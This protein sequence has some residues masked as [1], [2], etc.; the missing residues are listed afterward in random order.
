VGTLVR[1]SHLLD[2]LSD[3]I[4]PILIKETRQ[5]LKSR[6]FIVTFLLML[7]A[8]W[9]ISVFG[10]LTAG[11][12][13]EYGSAGRGL[14]MAYFVVLA[15]A[16]FIVVP[17]TAYRGLLAERDHTTLELL[18]IT[19]LSPRQL[20]WGKLW[21]AM[22]QV[23]I[24]YSAI[25]PFIAFTSMLQGFD[26]MLVSFALVMSG[27][28]SLCLTM[29]TLMLAA[30]PQGKNLQGLM[31]L[32]IAVGMFA[33]FGFI[34]STI[35][36]LLMETIP[37]DE[38]EFWVG[39]GAFVIAAVSF[40]FLFTQVATA[41]LTFESDNRSTGIR[42]ACT[43]QF[44]L[45]WLTLALVQYLIVGS[46]SFADS[47]IALLAMWPVL[48]TAVS[49]FFAVTEPDYVSRR[50][51]RNVP[52]RWYTRLLI[53]PLLPG[54]HRGFVYLMLHLLA[55]PSILVLLFPGLFS[56]S[57]WA[58]WWIVTMELYIVAYLG[59]GA[60]FG[61][62]L[63]RV[64]AEIRPMHVRVIIFLLFALG[65]IV[66]YLPLL[67]N[68]LDYLWPYRLVRVTNPFIILN[69]TSV[70]YGGTSGDVAIHELV[71]LW[72][73]AALGLLL[74]VRPMVAG[75]LEILRQPVS[76]AI[77][78]ESTSPKPDERLAEQPA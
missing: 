65:Q 10:T 26:I 21:S 36:I 47:E 33:I 73:A 45:Y 54:G 37:F 13:L 16:I 40:F 42:V 39:V 78:S 15:L 12:S 34:M 41:H 22:A 53:S 3:W 9:L 43:A 69:E 4:N 17:Y 67:F 68:D 50:I 57:H 27:L 2:E 72:I 46:S 5:A 1:A 20:V 59:L 62:A 51:R 70:G 14:F 44:A 19:S 28:V 76:P 52:R 6:Q 31:T 71:M 18:N 38:R 58:G 64:S 75:V 56:T 63:R 24:F 30:I 60:A 77:G 61:R 49:G 66:P 11:E 32:A 29:L 25:A 74:N 8:S 23:F 48:H 55:T 35:P 7:I